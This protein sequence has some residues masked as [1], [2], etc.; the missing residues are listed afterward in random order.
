MKTPN[1]Q[2]RFKHSIFLERN[3]YN[4][5]NVGW[6]WENLKNIMRNRYSATD[7]YCSS[8]DVTPW[9]F[10]DPNKMMEFMLTYSDIINDE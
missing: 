3:G 6:T 7:L 9:K 2:L 5:N 10:S 4:V 1:N 8:F